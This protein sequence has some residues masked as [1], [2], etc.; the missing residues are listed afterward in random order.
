MGG[1]VRGFFA[2]RMFFF[3]PERSKINFF[4]QTLAKKISNKKSTSKKPN[5]ELFTTVP[6]LGKK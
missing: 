5:Q 2:A 4:M 6:V 3:H 1:G